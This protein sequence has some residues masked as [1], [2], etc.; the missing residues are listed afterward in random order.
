MD[1]SATGT[2]A[3]G[4]VAWCR[5]ECTSKLLSAMEERIQWLVDATFADAG[6]GRRND[7]VGT[8]VASEVLRKVVDA[9]V[10]QL[11][12]RQHLWDHESAKRLRETGK[13]LKDRLAAEAKKVEGR[14]HVQRVREL[15]ER[16]QLLTDWQH[17]E[18]V[19]PLAGGSRILG[20]MRYDSDDALQVLRHAGE[21][22]KLKFAERALALGVGASE[23][24]RI[25]GALR[26]GETLSPIEAGHFRELLRDSRLVAEWAPVTTGRDSRARTWKTLKAE[27]ERKK[28]VAEINRKSGATR[29]PR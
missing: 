9:I 8:V 22:G 27:R 24:T 20:S 18:D 14:W 26:R 23:L 19:Q 10:V 17:A 1:A 16:E 6:V 28:A 2:G 13:G 11:F 3:E 15:E 25:L 5:S 29:R 21:L 7:E 12:Q 4:L